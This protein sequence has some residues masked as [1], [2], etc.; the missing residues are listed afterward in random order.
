MLCICSLLVFIP[1]SFAYD[2]SEYVNEF[3]ND[4]EF[5]EP[6]DFFEYQQW[7]Q[8]WWP[9]SHYSRAFPVFY[10]CCKNNECV[11]VIVDLNAKDLL[12]DEYFNELI[13]LN[14]I[15][16]SLSSGNLTKTYFVS[17]GLDSCF[18]YGGEHLRKGSLNLVADTAEQIASVQKTKT[19]KQV[20][21][22]IYFARSLELI[23][24]FN[25]ADF[26]LSVTCNYNNAKIKKSIEKLAEC[27]L[28]LSNIQNNFA[29]TGYVY[30]LDTCFDEAR[31]NLNEYH[32]N[33]IAKIKNVVDKTANVLYVIYDFLRG[34]FE[35]PLELRT[36][37][38]IEK[39]EYELAERI[40]AEIAGKKAYIHNSDRERIFL[41]YANRIMEKRDK[42]NK[43]ADIINQKITSVGNKIPNPIE[44]VF[45]DI[46]YEPNYNLSSARDL[47]DFSSKNYDYCSKLFSEV[48][49]NSA[50]R[51][52]NDSENNIN[53]AD[54][55]IT[56]EIAI[57]RKF[58]E[59]WNFIGFS[60]VVFAIVSY[61]LNLRRRS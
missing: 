40:S 31:L 22:V 13:D 57:N 2:T 6:I 24:P 51:C 50:V 54:S 26:A 12:K 56:K 18:P 28:Y 48:K 34:L 29:R 58:D 7:N 11:A 61:I 37:L 21:N 4:G 14:Y 55:I 39:T 52:L 44:V 20:S 53:N 8:R 49:Y 47:V 5:C 59:R 9:F 41:N 36:N 10:Q 35:Y 32:E 19:A 23:S 17:N 3:S 16:Y 38:S 15:K 42:F 60:I 33:E 30:R 27:N 25:V 45:S 1:L 43:K 46:F